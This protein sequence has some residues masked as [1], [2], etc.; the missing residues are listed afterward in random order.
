MKKN[1]ETICIHG[2]WKPTKGGEGCV[3]WTV[4]KILKA[5]GLWSFDGKKYEQAFGVTDSS[6][7]RASNG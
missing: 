1:L 5:R 4:E 7:D 2:G 6:P 3:R